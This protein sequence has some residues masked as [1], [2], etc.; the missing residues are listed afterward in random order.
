MSKTTRL[1]KI[2]GLVEA[3]ASAGHVCCIHH[4]EGVSITMLGVGP[5]RIGRAIDALGSELT[6]HVREQIRQELVTLAAEATNEF[7]DLIGKAGC[8]VKAEV[9]NGDCNTND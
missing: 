1:N 4:G 2:A 3:H 6:A 8:I 5:L 9:S 7:A